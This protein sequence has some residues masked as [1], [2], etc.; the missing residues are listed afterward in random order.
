MHSWVPISSWEDPMLGLDSHNNRGSRWVSS[1]LSQASRLAR[2]KKEIEL[3]ACHPY[4][5]FLEK[6]IQQMDRTD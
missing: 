1:L 5:R 6:V 4:D 3:V 2:I